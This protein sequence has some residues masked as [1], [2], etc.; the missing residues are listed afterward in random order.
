MCLCDAVRTLAHA[1]PTRRIGKHLSAQVRRAAVCGGGGEATPRTR[2]EC[3]F[4][5]CP[6]NKSERSWDEKEKVSEE[7]LKKSFSFDELSSDD[8]KAA[9]WKC[10]G[11]S[12]KA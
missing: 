12:V 5:P 3:P 10:R 9:S 11:P 8:Q 6:C 1:L 4:S 2:H 7:R